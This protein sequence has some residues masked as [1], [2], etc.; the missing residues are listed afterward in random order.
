MMVSD[1]RPIASARVQ[2]NSRSAPAFH[3]VMMPLGILF[4]PGVVG[5]WGHR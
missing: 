3:S 5:L 4:D 1:L 2:P